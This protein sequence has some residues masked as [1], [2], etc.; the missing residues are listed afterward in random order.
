[1][2]RILIAGAG[3]LLGINLAL[4]A[5][6]HYEVFGVLHDQTLNDPGFE[7][8]QADLLEPGEIARVLD[9]SKADWV[10]NCVAL[11]NL[12]AAE[13][14]PELAQRL[15]TE[16]PGRLA[17]ET[18]KRGMRFLQVSTDAVFDGVKGDY[19]EED[20][21][22]P[23][24]VYGRTKRL[25]EL[26]VKAAHPHVLIVRPNFFGWSVSGERSLAEFFYNNLS[27]N[28]ETPGYTD[29]I[30]CP[31]LATDLASMMLALLVKNSRGIYHAA[32][33]DQLSKY[34]FGVEIAKRFGLNA[35]LIRP[36]ETKDITAPRA[37]NL[38]LRTTRVA[39]VLGHRPPTIKEGIEKLFDQFQSGYRSRLLAMASL[40]EKVKG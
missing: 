5:A 13:Q 8:L 21:P 14:N 30:F 38:T 32:S 1:M 34:D 27:A 16:L 22:L 3:G 2:T 33:S 4:E 39:K 18:A 40:G 20:A 12:D 29:R 15:N 19:D 11:A 24:S 7:T 25:A 37:L 26:A 10:I 36:M 9:E 17:L 31:L 23:L 28:R 6:R 35:D